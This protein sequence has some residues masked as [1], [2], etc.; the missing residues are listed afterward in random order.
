MSVVEQ[1]A[2]AAAAPEAAPTP[3]GITVLGVQFASIASLFG[4]LQDRAELSLIHVN[5]WLNVWR[6]RIHPAAAIRIEPPADVDWQDWSFPP[7]WASRFAPWIMP[8]LARR[9]RRNWRQRGWRNPRLVITFPYFLPVA[10]E[11][12]L[13]RT[14]YYAVDNYQAFWP[15]RAT[16]VARQE[17]ELIRGAAAS[18]ATSSLLADWFKTRVPSCSDKVHY[19]PNGISPLMLRPREAALEGPAP[20][21]PRYAARFGDRTGPVVGH[22]ATIEPQYGIDLLVAAAERLPD[23]RFLIMGQV[24]P[25]PRRFADLVN[26]L[27]QLPNVLMTGRLQ[28]PHSRDVLAQC[29]LMILPVPLN[30]QSRYSCPNRLWTFMA[31]G[32]PIVSTPI[33]EV[34]KFGDLIYSGESIDEIVSALRAAAKERDR[35]RALARIEIAGAHTWPVLADQ[36]W[37]VLS[38]H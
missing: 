25:G 3:D 35:D 32:R 1:H 20:L 9:I 23:F 8:V 6:G 37:S 5:D 30:A 10:R 28:V 16:T 29:D 18:V 33:P 22:Y 24:L 13:E 38:V 12:G 31:T 4:P 17:D 36:M 26:K 27:S 19:I 34:T 11:I 14:L 15:D 7:G 21:Q 2:Y